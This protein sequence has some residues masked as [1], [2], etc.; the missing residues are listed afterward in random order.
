MPSDQMHTS[1]HVPAFSGL[2]RWW[3]RLGLGVENRGLVCPVWPLTVNASLTE[4]REGFASVP[5]QLAV[6]AP[7]QDKTVMCLVLIHLEGGGPNS[8]A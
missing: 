4:G 7:V 2:D 6:W 3:R 8:V 5:P 1:P